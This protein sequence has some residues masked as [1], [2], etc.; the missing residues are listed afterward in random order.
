MSSERGRTT[1]EIKVDQ[2]CKSSNRI[3][4]PNTRI[5]PT[6]PTKPKGAIARAMALNLMAKAQASM[7]L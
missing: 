6:Q 4:P 3:L 5:K 2:L 7:S 1:S